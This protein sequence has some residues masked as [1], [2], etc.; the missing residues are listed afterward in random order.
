MSLHQ[1]YQDKN[2]HNPTIL[3][4]SYREQEDS[5][6]A[7]NNLYRPSVARVLFRPFANLHDIR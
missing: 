7:T 1:S 5:Q 6:P 3:L 2:K 4:Q